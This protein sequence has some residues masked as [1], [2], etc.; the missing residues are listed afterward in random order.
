[1]ESGAK[2]QEC[3]GVFLEVRDDDVAASPRYC[4]SVAFESSSMG[5]FKQLVAF[6][7]GSRPMV[8]R[9]IMVSLFKVCGYFFPRRFTLNLTQFEDYDGRNFT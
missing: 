2:L 9:E 7:F 3:P 5:S 1:M 8:V 6:D 4:V